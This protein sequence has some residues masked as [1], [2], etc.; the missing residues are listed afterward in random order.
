[1]PLPDLAAL[2]QAAETVHAVFPATPQVHWP[3][4]SARAGAEVWVKHENHTP[5]GAF[6]VRG[7]IVHM[8]NL[9]R[10]NPGLVGVIT[11][12]RGNHGQSIALAAAAVGLKA[13]VVVPHGNSVEKNAAM[14]ALGAELVEHGH[15]FQ[16][17]YEHAVA[18]ATG[19]GLHMVRSFQDDLVAGVGTYALELFAA[20]ADIDTVYVPIGLGSGICG[21]IAARDALGLATKVVGVVAAGAPAYALSFKAG[22]AVSTNSADT[23]ADGMACRVPVD[24]AVAIIAKGADRVVTVDDGEI[25]AAMRHYFTDTHNV[26]EGAGAAPLAALLQE[27]QRMAGKRVALILSGGNVDR[28]VYAPIL[29]APTLA[30]ATP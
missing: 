20:V 27:R 1:M 15:D 18:S 4:L 12:T 30:E 25:A 21:T 6:K 22:R 19:R 13:T 8:A 11:A 9:K 2:R 3:L 24:E 26:A 14:R 10:D 28:A 5:V 17:A 7:G 16:A 23:M 29:A